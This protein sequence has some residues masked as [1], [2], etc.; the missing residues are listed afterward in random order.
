MED[1]L[2]RRDLLTTGGILQSSFLYGKRDSA[3]FG[4]KEKETQAQD[5]ILRERI[6]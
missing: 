2:I 1:C 6:V 4:K 5:C 3:S